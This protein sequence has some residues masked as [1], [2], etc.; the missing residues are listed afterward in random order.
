MDIAI[1][2]TSC[3]ANQVQVLLLTAIVYNYLRHS[4]YASAPLKNGAGGILHSGMSV[5]E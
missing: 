1:F 3:T 5:C 4:F 2:Q